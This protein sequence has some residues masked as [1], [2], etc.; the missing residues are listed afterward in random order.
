[1]ISLIAGFSLPK[2]IGRVFAVAMKEAKESVRAAASSTW[3]LPLDL[4]KQDMDIRWNII[5]S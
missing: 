4:V 3:M 5:V 1:M 2:L